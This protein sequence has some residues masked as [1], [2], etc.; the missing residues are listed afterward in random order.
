MGNCAQSPSK[1][2]GHSF[3]S[4][5]HSP[6]AAVVDNGPSK[7]N[8]KDLHHIPLMTCL[9]Q[10]DLVREKNNQAQFDNEDARKLVL[11]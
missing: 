11:R 7:I 9:K 10:R 5:K 2:Q 6:L 4:I 8:K 3:S 1:G